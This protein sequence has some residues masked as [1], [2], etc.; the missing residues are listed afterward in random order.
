MRVVSSGVRLR[1]LVVLAVMKAM[2][3]GMKSMST[4]AA[5]RPACVTGTCGTW[6]A[7]I[8]RASLV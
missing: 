4:T 3:M 2:M 8:V 1:D 6:V 7:A 5:A